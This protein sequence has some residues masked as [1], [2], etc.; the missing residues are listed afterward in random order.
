VAEE[1]TY[2]QK[3]LHRAGT[4]LSDD[5][6][7]AHAAAEREHGRPLTIKQVLLKRVEGDLREV[8]DVVVQMEPT[9]PQPPE[10]TDASL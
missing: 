6:R 7:R 5:I 10:T 1:L 9:A 8:Y 4:I 2:G 3:V